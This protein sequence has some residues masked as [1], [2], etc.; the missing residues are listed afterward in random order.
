MKPVISRLL[1]V[2]LILFV[3]LI[4]AAPAN[5][6]AAVSKKDKTSAQAAY[7]LGEK[8]KWAEFERR[9]KS[10]KDPLLNKI[11]HWYRLQARASGANFEEI[12][13]FIEKEPNWPSQR[14]LL[15][16]AEQAMKASTDRD[17]ILAWF[18]KH[19]PLTPNGVAWMAG[20]KLL[21]GHK[22]DAIRMVKDVW[23]SGNF[24]FKQERH[25][26]RQF[27]Q[28][29]TLD[30]HLNR[31]DRLLWDGKYYP[32]RRMYRRFKDPKYRAL[33][34]ARLTLR[35]MRGGVDRA[36]ERVPADLKDHPGLV[37][38]RLRW[39]RRKGRDQDAMT[40][41]QNPP[42]DLIEP[43]RWWT[44]RAIL[45]RR[46]LRK[47][48][49]S[50]AYRLTQDHRLNEEDAGNM[51]EAEWMAG[52]IA[53]RFLKDNK[54]AYDHFSKIYG[55]ASYPISQTRGAYWAG[56]AAEAMG[57]AEKA[58]FWYRTA[59]LHETTYYGQLAAAKIPEAKKLDLPA[60]P[61]ADSE[62]K[63]SFEKDELVAAVRTIRKAGLRE[64][65]R[66]FIRQLSRR[67]E[68]EEWQVLTAALAKAEG[69]NDLAILVSRA[70]L[71]DGI[72]LVEA[73]YP[74]LKH[75]LVTGVE[76]AFVHAIIRQES[77]FNP[78]AVSHA[79]ARGLMQIM[80]GTARQVAKQNSK[81][82]SRRKLTE[83][84][85]Y[86]L[87]LGQAYLRDLLKEFN[88]SYILTLAAYNAGPHRAKRWIKRNGDP[89]DKT[90]DA[91]DWVEMIPISETRNYVQ[92]VIENLHVYRQL[93]ANKE[94]AF[95]PQGA[96]GR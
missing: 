7:K 32:V 4:G 26:H 75:K 76:P 9:A 54:V 31:L 35:R 91:I 23:V 90:V 66:P 93:L 81:R 78:K 71:R 15:I 96:L 43:G 5:E 29:M 45:A 63:K 34:E 59:F 8:A 94:V 17:A 95:K 85:K 70:A 77:A 50:D 18:K 30:D 67:D 86:N 33:A 74:V 89:R 42:D 68:R 36:I 72:E 73:G 19:P 49:I 65:M 55:V 53:L 13:R 38:E 10:V 92:R 40:L 27:G 41:L 64:I 58:A 37:Y 16:R 6:A 87:G 69:R 88:D 21:E 61:K 57:E 39:R 52:W 51:I 24:G 11:L 60:S 56:R 25:F 22:D 83:D 28:Y 14:R 3:V 46:A 2:S 84:E 79:G 62:L 82:Y 44:E 20:E 1:A 12:S 48:H 47:G 80:P